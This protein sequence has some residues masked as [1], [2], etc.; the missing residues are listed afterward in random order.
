MWRARPGG[1]IESWIWDWALGETVALTLVI[2]PQWAWYSL[3]S[4]CRGSGYFIARTV[5][6]EVPTNIMCP[7][8][9]TTMAV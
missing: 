5:P 8:W 7:E 9:E 3:N 2:G 1:S 6:T 4:F